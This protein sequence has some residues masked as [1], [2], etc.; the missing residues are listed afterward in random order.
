VTTNGCDSI[1]ELTLSVTN[2]FESDYDFT[3]CEGDTLFFGGDTL[4]KTGIFIDSLAAQG[5]CDSIIKVRLNVVPF[6]GFNIDTVLCFGDSFEIANNVYK[7][8]GVYRD[9]LLGES[10]DSV[11]ISFVQVN[12]EIVLG[13]VRTVVRPSGDGFIEPTVTGGT[14]TLSYLW[15]T[16][17]RTPVLDSVMAGTYRLT[18]TDQTSCSAIFDLELDPATAVSDRFSESIRV[19]LFPNPIRVSTEYSMIFEGAEGSVFQIQLFDL[20]GRKLDSHQFKIAQNKELITLNAPPY[21]GM[22][23]LKIADARGQF[24][25]R[26]LMV[27]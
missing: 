6:I 17:A 23:T 19:Q 24:S 14:G 12:P 27:H 10:C 25:M 3:I 9:T 16:G 2:K 11:V 13:D 4:T 5:G 15:S 22:Y 8:D 21:A 20:N 1:I 18:V 26:K 7:V